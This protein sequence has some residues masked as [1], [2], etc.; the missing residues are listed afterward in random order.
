MS[1]LLEIL[2]ELVLPL[3]A[4]LLAE[5]ALHELVRLPWAW[6]TGRVILTAIIYFG[7]GLVAGFIS[8]LIFPEAFAR[9]STLPGISLVIIPVLGGLLMSY[10]AWFRVRTW[11]WTIRL[12]TFAYGYL[13][14]FAMTLLRFYFTE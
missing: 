8:L 3:F 13:F 2:L 12:E 14:A 11:D 10:I 9:S 4:E 6:K 7:V 5:V 1:I